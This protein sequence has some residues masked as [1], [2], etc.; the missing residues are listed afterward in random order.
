MVAFP[1]LSSI[2]IAPLIGAIIALFIKGEEKTISKNLR[3]LALWTSIVELVLVIILIV[4]FDFSNADFQFIEKKNILIKFGV[5]YH[6]GIDSISLVFIMLTTVLFPLCF[7][8]TRLSIKFRTREF[9][10]SMLFLEALTVGVFC[11]LD[12]VLFLFSSI[13]KLNGDFKNSKPI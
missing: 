6:L 9:V 8:Y 1:I 2:I 10:I 7:F 3:E 12:I 13:K 11:S 4:Q 5:S